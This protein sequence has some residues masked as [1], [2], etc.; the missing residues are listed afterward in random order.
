MGERSVAERGGDYHRDI[1]VVLSVTMMVSTLFTS[2]NV[3]STVDVPLGRRAGPDWSVGL[4]IGV[5]PRRAVDRLRRS[6]SATGARRGSPCSRRCRRRSPDGY[7]CAASGRIFWS[8]GRSSSCESSNWRPRSL[9]GW[10][11]RRPSSASTRTPTTRR[12]SP[13]A[14]RRTTPPRLP[15]RARHL[16]QRPVSGIDSRRRPGTGPGH[17]AER[18]VRDARAASLQR[19]ASIAGFT[20]VESRLGYDDSGM[21][22]WPQN[23]RPRPS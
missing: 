8:P 12:S 18:T 17:D 2:V 7:C 3:V 13:R 6:T 5:A 14:S 23:D 4:P 20:R 19:A 11:L 22:G 15:G 16:H 10:N 21:T 1:L 9:S